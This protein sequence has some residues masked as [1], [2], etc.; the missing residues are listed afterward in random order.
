MH[1]DDHPSPLPRPGVR[2]RR[3]KALGAGICV[4]A[5]LAAAGCTSSSSKASGGT[6]QGTGSSGGSVFPGGT[7]LQG[8]TLLMIIYT[9]PLAAWNPPLNAGK[10]VEA[11]TGVKVNVQNP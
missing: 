1:D 5:L 11:S 10:A 4:L 9:P 3:L 6:S 8:K 7:S 2:G